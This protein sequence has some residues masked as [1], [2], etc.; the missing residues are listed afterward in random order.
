M[1]L[2]QPGRKVGDLLNSQR[3]AWGAETATHFARLTGVPHESLELIAGDL[4]ADITHLAMALGKDPDEFLGEVAKRAGAAIADET[5]ECP[6]EAEESASGEPPFLEEP[7][8]WDDLSHK[9]HFIVAGRR[10]GDDETTVE[11]VMVDT[12]ETTPW[13]HFVEHVLYRGT[14][15]AAKFKELADVP[16]WQWPKEAELKI[17]DDWYEEE[18]DGEWAYCD[19]VFEIPGPPLDPI[20]AERE[21]NQGN[22]GQEQREG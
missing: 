18:S 4:L 17:P 5:R 7:W 1:T 12:R 20:R 19:G 11:Y 8:A 21:F 16:A 13:H 9:R 10:H 22:D 14:I 15:P 3:A 6:H 2:F